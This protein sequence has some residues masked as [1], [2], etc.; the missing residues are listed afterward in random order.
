MVA[1]PD[2]MVAA[3]FFLRGLAPAI[4]ASGFCAGE[5]AAA[6]GSESGRSGEAAMIVASESRG[7]AD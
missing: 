6:A 2:T 5:S 4:V 1:S 7:V 3:L